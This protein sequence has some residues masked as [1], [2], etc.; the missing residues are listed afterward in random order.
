MANVFAQF[1]KEAK[2]KNVFAQF[3]EAEEIDEPLVKKIDEALLKIPGASTVAEFAAGANRSIMGFL[4]FVGPDN[5][6][7]IL[8]VSGADTRVPRL[9]NEL[10]A[11]QGTFNDGLTGEIA[12]K[13]GELAS[14]AVGGGA[15][16]RSAA[17]QLSPLAAAGESAGLGLLRQMGMAKP[18]ADAVGGAASGVGSVVGREFGGPEGELIGG[19]LAP[20]AV[21]IPLTSAKSVANKLLQKSAPSSDELRTAASGIYKSLDEAGVT[22]PARNYNT[23]AD[24]V[25][26]TLKKEGADKDLTPKAM[27]VISRLATDKGKDKTLSE[28]DTLRKIANNAASSL[29]PADARLGII[30]KQKIDDFLDDI[31][32]EVVSGKGAGTAYRSARDLWQRARKSEDMDIL[33]LNADNQGSGK[34]NGIRVQFR[35][36][37]KRINTGKAKGYSK[38]EVEAIR[39]IVQG[40]RSGNTARFLGKFGIMD[41]VT[42]RTLTTM[43]GAGLAGA[44]TGSGWVAAAVPL[45]GNMSGALAQRMTQ[46]NAA[47]AQS[48]IRAGKSGARIAE[49]YIKNTP[50]NLRST[51]ELAEL[52]LKNKVPLASINTAKSSPLLSDA[53]VI[54]SAAQI[55][56][57]KEEMKGNK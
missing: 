21:S 1:D 17:S 47:M 22:V 13:A 32:D 34:E 30:A 44:A 27:A 53:A 14:M 18:A 11:P 52:L 55:N 48:I 41:G 45:I 46:N 36:L 6:N 9:S 25:A 16:L 24:D 7:A 3:S 40:T 26:A 51:T 35:A 57:R 8:E 43:G 56:D 37:L 2:P 54:A 39:K 15:A 31:P 12:G 20:L 50:K 23:L 5:I 38:E 28:L 29:D 49:L 10:A 42:S 19:I 33:L 4:D